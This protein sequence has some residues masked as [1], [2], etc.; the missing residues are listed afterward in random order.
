MTNEL[1][2]V[3]RA[4]LCHGGLAVTPE[5]VEE[6]LRL[7]VGTQVSQDEALILLIEELVRKGRPA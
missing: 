4:E 1:I 6:A 5:I 3:M 7:A 2:D